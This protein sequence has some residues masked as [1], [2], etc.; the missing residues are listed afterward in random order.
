MAVRDNSGKDKAQANLLR[1]VLASSAGVA[2]TCPDPEI[3]SAYADRALDLE[4]TARYELHFS[5]C[6]HCREQLAAMSRA[7]E[8]VDLA[9]VR[10]LSWIWTWGWIALAPVTAMLLIAAILIARHPAANRAAEQPLV[11]MQAPQR[12][13]APSTV[14]LDSAQAPEQLTAEQPAKTAP[15]AKASRMRS[16][17]GSAQA[18]IAPASPRSTNE[19]SDRENAL[20]ADE[21]KKEG[22]VSGSD[23]AAGVRNDVQLD[24]S[25][26]AQQKQ[27]PRSGVQYAQKEGVSTQ[28]QTVTVESEVSSAAAPAPSLSANGASG[29]IS[30][31]NAGAPPGAAAARKST[32]TIT[33]NVPSNLVSSQMV[34]VESA[35]DRDILTIVRSP[36]PQVLWRISS[37]RFVERSSDAGATWRTQWTNPS[38]RVVA[39]SAPSVDTCWLVGGGGIVLVTK[40]GKKW[41]AVEPPVIEDFVAVSAVDAFSATITATDGHKFE[42]HDGGKHWLPAP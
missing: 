42:T 34:T 38:A 36:D 32:A 27:T 1:R 15:A 7:A 14:P 9:P 3:L 8:P 35:A 4:E 11:A 5:Q 30:S 20:P 29:S 18:F 10:R 31:G 41:H 19:E 24:K 37:G 2:E 26:N 25:A 39:G 33:V 21:K 12:V 28:N 17:T 40:D 13:P 6:A 22:L 23:F 16:E